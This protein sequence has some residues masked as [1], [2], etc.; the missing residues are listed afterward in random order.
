[1]K[2]NRKKSRTELT[3]EEEI[4][5]DEVDNAIHCLLAELSGWKDSQGT[6]DLNWNIELISKVRGV[7]QEVICKDLQIM[8]E[9]EFYPYL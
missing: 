7:V 3:R 6:S 2:K 9:K 1:M 8:M 4:K 5:Q